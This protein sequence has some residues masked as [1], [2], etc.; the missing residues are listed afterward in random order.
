M[1]K[2][3]IFIFIFVVCAAVSCIGSYT[4]EYILVLIG[5]IASAVLGAIISSAFEQ[6]ISCEQ[7]IKLWLQQKLYYKRDIRLSFSY[8]FKIQIDGKYLL[9]K[10]NRLKNQFQPIGGVYKFYLEAKPMLESFGYRPDTKMNNFKESDDLRIVIKGKY[11]LEY[12]KWFLSMKDR[13][14]DPCREFT[15]EL[16]NSHLLP[17]ELFKN[18]KYRKISVHNEGVTYSKYNSC[19]EF[20]YSDI[21]E[22]SLTDEQKNSIL[23]AVENHPDKLCLASAEELSSEC[24]GGIEK[25]IGNN[26]KWLIGG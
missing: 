3:I 12:L 26:A 22:L 14:F 25:N 9:I 19:Q 18:I 15:E 24:Y 8:L 1:V 23:E 10:G 16:I 5:S 2:S 20:I 4:Q 11:L 13:E 6:L 21:F 17:D 7:G